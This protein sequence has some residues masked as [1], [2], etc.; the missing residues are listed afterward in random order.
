MAMHINVMH[1]QHLARIQTLHNSA[2]SILHATMVVDRD[3]TMVVDRDRTMVVDR[4]RTLY[5]SLHGI[6][7]LYSTPFQIPTRTLTDLKYLQCDAAV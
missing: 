3:R 2:Y 4:D 6:L 7:I 5:M 1:H